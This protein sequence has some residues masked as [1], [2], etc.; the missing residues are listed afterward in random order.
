MLK[1][2][3]VA[4]SADSNNKYYLSCPEIILILHFVFH[5]VFSTSR[6][7]KIPLLLISPLPQ[8]LYLSQHSSMQHS[9]DVAHSDHKSLIESSESMACPQ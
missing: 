2:A 6:K 9:Y 1:P 8:C 7:L 4:V 5:F 3:C